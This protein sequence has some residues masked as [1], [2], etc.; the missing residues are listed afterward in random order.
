MIDAL[1]QANT[2]I[3][4]HFG[5]D[6]VSLIVFGSSCRK[7]SFNITSD[8]DYIL[9]L[10]HLDKPQD[11]ISR[12]LKSKMAHIFP[13]VAFNIYSQDEFSKSIANNAWLALTIN[14][15]YRTYADNGGYFKN[16]I[17]KK[18]AEVKRLKIGEI[19]WYYEQKEFK[20]VVSEHYDKLSTDYE[21]TAE[22]S[23]SAGIQNIALE[24]L[25][26]SVHCFMLSK[27]T[28]I[29]IFTTK[30]ELVQF[31]FNFFPDEDIFNLKEV[32]LQLEQNVGQKYTFDFDFDGNMKFPAI[33]NKEA[34][35]LYEQSSKAFS[36]LKRYFQK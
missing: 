34:T 3:K 22:L 17:D 13:L 19:D 1:E 21:K 8:I 27:L 35:Q 2:I 12:E 25:L 16:T 29:K 36:I 4:S 6:L 14:L 10:K 24:L 5:D 31:F 9:I 30:G 7:D 18:V 32:F 28:K 11:A 26:G 20:P 23:Y 15:G 33:D